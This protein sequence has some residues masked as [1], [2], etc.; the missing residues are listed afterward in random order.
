MRSALGSRIS[1]MAGGKVLSAGYQNNGYGNI[2]EI[3][4][5]NGFSTKYAHLNKIYVTK[6]HE[7]KQGQKIGLSGNT[8]IGTG[9]HL[10]FGVH[11]YGKGDD[12][13]KYLP[14]F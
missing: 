10:H 6:G 9:P 5:G 1:A 3:D 8:G 12:P 11:K 7:I 2:V 4:H 13:V 14:N